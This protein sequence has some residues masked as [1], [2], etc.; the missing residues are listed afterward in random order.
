MP[1]LGACI[2]DLYMGKKNYQLMARQLALEYQKYADRTNPDLFVLVYVFR[3]QSTP[4]GMIACDPRLQWWPMHLHSVRI[5][6]ECPLRIVVRPAPADDVL[7]VLP[8]DSAS[9]TP[10]MSMPMAITI[11]CADSPADMTVVFHGLF[12]SPPPM[13]DM[14][15]GTTIYATHYYGHTGDGVQVG[16]RPDGDHVFAFHEVRMSLDTLY[17]SNG[18]LSWPALMASALHAK[19][20]DA[21]PLRALCKDVIDAHANLRY[22]VALTEQA[23]SQTSHLFLQNHVPPFASSLVRQQPDAP[24]NA[25]SPAPASDGRRPELRHHPRH[26]AQ[27]PN[28]HNSSFDRCTVS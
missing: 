8:H 10:H 21:H 16:M 24:P 23:T 9:S 18:N 28:A 27:D 25:T 15:D 20:D 22:A 11:A 19:F 6:R 3:Q 14:P 26:Y 12:P 13:R 7:I 2:G 4:N 1:S 5:D 17:E